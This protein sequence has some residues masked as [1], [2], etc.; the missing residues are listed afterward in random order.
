MVIAAGALAVASVAGSVMSSNATKHAVDAQQKIADDNRTS[1]DKALDRQ[2]QVANDTL[3]FNKQQYT[4]AKQRQVGIDAT[5]QKVV[6]QNLDLSAK[7]GQRA[8]EQYDFYKTNGQPVV[9][10]A[11][12]DASNWDSQGNIDAARGRAGADVQQ[13]YDNTTQQNQRALSRMGVNPSSGRFLAV[14]QRTQADQA[15][16]T[17]GAETNA[18]QGVRTQAV[19]MRQQASNL[20]Q[21][22][23][24]QSMQESGTSTASGA[25]AVNAANT[26]AAQNQ[27]I[28]TST[29]NG[30]ATAASIYG[31]AASGYGNLYGQAQKQGM[32]D[33]NLGQQEQAGWG[34][35]MGMAA[36]LM[37]DGGTVGG[38]KNEA[39][40]G[41][42]IRGPGT[43]T[44][45]S[46][47][48]V[49]SSTGRPVRLSN[50]EYVVSADTVRALGTKYFDNLQAKHHTP[51]NVGR[52]A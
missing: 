30:N 52:A 13:A 44:S 49:N 31:S 39:G 37:A 47:S 40:R 9:K 1:A 15:A 45:D 10:K 3:E 25:G 35:M 16:T 20:A 33:Q 18:E 12:D 28:T 32:F 4:D 48:A 50:G 17:A 42:K 7:A 21:G 19:G 22:M 51:V 38:D 5:N 46:V 36:G 29:I 26:G 27:A 23:P 34:S 41:G 2:T 11:L 43:G 8:D 6:D 14:Q 24:A